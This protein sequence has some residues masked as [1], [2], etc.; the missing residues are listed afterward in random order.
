MMEQPT[1]KWSVIGDKFSR[2]ITESRDDQK[3]EALDEFA[4]KIRQYEVTLEC[5][6]LLKS[7][8]AQVLV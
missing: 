2:Q 5:C 7:T 3:R 4:S 1:I 6:H 8:F